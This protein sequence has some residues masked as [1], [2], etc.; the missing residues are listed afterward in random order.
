VTDTNQL[1]I[2]KS[3]KS[4]RRY[5]REF[6]LGI[7]IVI[8]ALVVI[9]LVF[10]AP[11]PKPPPIPFD[12]ALESM[13]L[14]DPTTFA[15]ELHDSVLVAENNVEVACLLGNEEDRAKAAADAG[16][17]AS[18]V[19]RYMAK[20]KRMKPLAACEAAVKETVELAA[21]CMSNTLPSWR[22][23]PEVPEYANREACGKEVGAGHGPLPDDDKV[24]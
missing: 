6:G 5:F 20:N 15:L 10:G 18:T 22:Q 21:K 19:D 9:R 1:A 12:T 13:R 2:V 4:T 3:D 11:R 8:A 24:H 17:L 23:G 7:C 16:R 14:A